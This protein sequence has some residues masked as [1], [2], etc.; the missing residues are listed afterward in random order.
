MTT[1]P[2]PEARS[3]A[4]V[5]RD[6]W[7][8]I[9]GALAAVTAANALWMLAA[10]AHWYHELP[11]N[12]PATGAYNEHFVRDIGCAFAVMAMALGWAA[13]RPAVRVP[14]LV[15]STSFLV[16]HAGLHVF[17]SW[18]GYLPAGHWQ[19]DVAGVYLPAIASVALTAAL[20]RRA[21]RAK[22]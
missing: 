22:R 14:L 8:W 1:T 18:R 17:D 16:A 7:T 4:T 20:L 21:R 5:A 12:V 3:G 15:I 6:G 10:P 2:L 19:H 11:A 9:L 13:L